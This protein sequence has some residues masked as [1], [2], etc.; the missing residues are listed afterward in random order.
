MPSKRIRHIST[1]WRYGACF[2]RLFYPPIASRRKSINQS[3]E[4]SKRGGMGGGGR[5]C[6]KYNASRSDRGGGRVENENIIES[7]IIFDTDQ[8]P[9]TQ[10][11]P[12][13]CRYTGRTRTSSKSN[14]DDDE[15]ARCR[16]MPRCPPSP[17]G[18]S[19]DVPK[20]HT[21]LLLLL[22]LWW[23]W[24]IIISSSP[25]RSARPCRD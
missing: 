15:Y 12:Y 23:W 11:T 9:T 5:G 6:A 24:L 21:F 2:S 14:D 20:R 19:A 4:V 7:I 10:L 25:R 8:L 22:C 17:V 18:G 16:T 13:M 3:C 1:R